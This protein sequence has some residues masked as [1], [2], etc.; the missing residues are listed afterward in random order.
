MGGLAKHTIF[1]LSEVPSLTPIPVFPS[2]LK[3]FRGQSD[4]EAWGR[5][6]LSQKG[7]WDQP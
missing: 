4:S 6:W 1:Q 7:G 3:C 5:N 2:P